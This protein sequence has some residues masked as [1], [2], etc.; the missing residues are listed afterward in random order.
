ML[1]SIAILA[2]FAVQPTDS[3]LPES[4]AENLRDTIPDSLRLVDIELSSSIDAK[5][6]TPVSIEWKTAPRAGSNSVQLTFAL[7]EGPT[8]RWAFVRLAPS[9]P[10]LTYRRTLPSGHTL[11]EADLMVVQR[12]EGQGLDLLP[13]SL[14]GQSLSRSVSEGES[15]GP[16]SVTLP[17]PV[18]S[19][20]PVDVI[21]RVGQVEVQLS[22]I[23]HRSVRP[24]ARGKVRVNSGRTLSGRLVDRN[25]F[26]LDTIGAPP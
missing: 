25:T 23:L 13:S 11:V 19:R 10:V 20:S 6:D 17:S 9:T 1:T 2:L 12:A 14:V 5:A 18:P 16:E 21:A 8:R 22:G 4:V 3:A 24:G 15:V 26:V 7:P